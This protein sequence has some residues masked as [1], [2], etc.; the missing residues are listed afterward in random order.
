MSRSLATVNVGA[1]RRRVVGW[2]FDTNSVGRYFR[3]LLC[4]EQRL[5]LGAVKHIQPLRMGALFVTS[6]P[7]DV[8]FVAKAIPEVSQEFSTAFLRT[9]TA[10][11]FLHPRIS[12]L[13]MSVGLPKSVQLIAAAFSVL[14]I[15]SFWPYLEPRGSFDDLL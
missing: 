9:F 13:A 5:K 14:Y 6:F 4:S 12:R 15:R 7:V 11:V 10:R 8:G 2:R 3:V 1:Q